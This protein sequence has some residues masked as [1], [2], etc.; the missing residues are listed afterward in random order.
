MTAWRPVAALCATRLA[1][2]GPGGQCLCVSGDQQQA[3]ALGA[4]EGAIGVRRVSGLLGA[5]LRP[6]WECRASRADRGLWLP[7]RG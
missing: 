4:D 5:R 3:L 7:P 2:A 1:A 6:G